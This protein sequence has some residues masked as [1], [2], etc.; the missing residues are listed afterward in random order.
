MQLKEI[1]EEDVSINIKPLI[2][3]FSFLFSKYIHLT[4]LV[5]DLV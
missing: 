1:E 5:V 4:V 2:M 3:L